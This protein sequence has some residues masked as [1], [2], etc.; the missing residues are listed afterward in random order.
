MRQTHVWGTVITSHDK[1]KAE[2]SK[3]SRSRR[4]CQIK[5]RTVAK[6]RI[7]EF[8]VSNASAR[9]AS[10]AFSDLPGSRARQRD[11]S[12][13]AQVLKQVLREFAHVSTKVK[14]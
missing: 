9:L 13:L 2:P 5:D 3:N 14:R 11:T 1:P 6:D 8:V 12:F 7:I 10:D 4:S